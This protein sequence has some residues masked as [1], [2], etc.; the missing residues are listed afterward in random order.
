MTGARSHEL[1]PSLCPSAR[2]IWHALG[3][4]A[5]SEGAPTL[6]LPPLISPT[7][8]PRSRSPR[9]LNGRSVRRFWA[10]SALLMGEIS[11]LFSD[12]QLSR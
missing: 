12:A 1:P 3:G 4:R 7:C 6:N 8:L 9:S 11:P 10:I 2:V 5:S